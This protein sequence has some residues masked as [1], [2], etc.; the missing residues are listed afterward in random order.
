[1]WARGYRHYCM[2]V[3]T[4]PHYMEKNLKDMPNNKAYLWKDVVFYGALPDEDNGYTIIFEKGRDKLIIHQYSTNKNDEQY[5]RTEKKY[6][7]N[8]QGTARGGRSGGRGQGQQNNRNQQNSDHRHN[9]TQQNSDH[10]NNRTQQ[11]QQPQQNNRNIRNNRHRPN[12]EK[13][14]KKSLLLNR[15]K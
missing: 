7:D 10:R 15:K 3:N 13:Y 1:M 4:L 5:K 9:R 14:E 11:T 8:Q 2:A 12:T 6:N